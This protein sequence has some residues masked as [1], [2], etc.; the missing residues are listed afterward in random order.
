[1]LEVREVL[2]REQRQEIANMMAE[3][4]GRRGYYR[5]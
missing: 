1:M 5:Q 4:R 2:T 3:Y